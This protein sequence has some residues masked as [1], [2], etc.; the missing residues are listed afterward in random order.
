[1][2]RRPW[3]GTS[4]ALLLGAAALVGCSHS[5]ERRATTPTS[6]ATATSLSATLTSPVD[7]ALSWRATDPRAAGEAV[8]FATDPKGPYTLLQYLP[9]GQDTFKHAN[10]IHLK[11]VIEH[12]GRPVL[13]YEYVRGKT[14][15]HQ[16]VTPAM[17]LGFQEQPWS[18]RELL[19]WKR[20]RSKAPA[21]S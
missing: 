12:E 18:V 1:V 14:N 3:T 2:S 13:V 15:K 20:P 11:E 16:H 21:R 5:G 6:P 9:A 8:E 10:L 4:A 17:S 7:I 19:A